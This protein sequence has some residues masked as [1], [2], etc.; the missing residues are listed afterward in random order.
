M[1]IADFLRWQYGAGVAAFLAAWANL[2]WF[3]FHFFS[4][5]LLIKS[6]AAPFH[7]I[8]ERKSPGFN[9]EELFEVFIVN[10]LMRVVGVFVRTVFI[11][12]GVVAEAALFAAALF[13]FVSYLLLPLVPF[14]A[15]VAGIII[16]VL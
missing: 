10:T 1:L 3:V 7:R 5:P 4:I 8:R 2:H 14:A 12:V 13:L 11:L 6:F 15:I 16:M 9:P